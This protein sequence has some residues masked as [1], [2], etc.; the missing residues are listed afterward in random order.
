MN[1]CAIQ[2][3]PAR[4]AWGPADPDG[5]SRWLTPFE[6]PLTRSGWPSRWSGAPDPATTPSAALEA[7]DVGEAK[8]RLNGQRLDPAR[9]PAQED[10]DLLALRGALSRLVAGFPSHQQQAVAAVLPGSAPPDAPAFT[11]TL[12]DQLFLATVNPHVARVVGLYHVDC[13]A[14]AGHS[15]YLS[16]SESSIAPASASALLFLRRFLLGF[17]A[18]CFLDGLFLGT[19]FL[20]G[21][22]F[23]RRLF[24]LRLR[25]PLRSWSCGHAA[26]V[27]A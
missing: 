19:F 3:G 21:L 2:P 9:S 17:L 15:P 5:W 22:L 14:V 13:T 1:A 18:A 4:A 23:L 20:R 11:L 10:A 6:P 27:T 7:A 25:G 24:R 12:F 16:G 26:R 8:R